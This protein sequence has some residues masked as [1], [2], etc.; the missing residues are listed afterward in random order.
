MICSHFNPAITICFATWQGFPWKKVPYYIFAQVFGAFIAGLML[1]GQYHEQITAFAAETTAAGLGTVFNGGP[2]S[3]LCSFPGETQ[4]SLG[5]LFLIE[6]FVDSYIVSQFDVV[7]GLEYQTDTY[8][9]GIVIWACLDPANPF[10]APSSA[11]FCIG[12]AYATMIWGFA[13]ITISTNLARDLGTR[14]VA[15]IFFG[16]EAFSYKNYSW[17]SILVNVFATLFATAY[18]EM[19]MRDSL[20]KISKGAAVHEGGEQGLALHL[21]KS[22]I[23]NP[24]TGNGG[25]PPMEKG[26]TNATGYSGYGPES[27]NG[28]GATHR[29][30]MKDM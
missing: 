27:V 22:G 16:G 12:L 6:F 15:A 8:N 18:Y 24:K 21:T 25:L 3:I 11:P 13:N 2:A 17:I 9:Q 7:N 14:I 10:V 20:Q 1:M 29:D 28:N 4:N 30:V 5:Y 23:Y 26:I 19:L